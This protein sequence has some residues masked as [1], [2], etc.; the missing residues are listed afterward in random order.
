M[1]WTLGA[2][3]RGP[4]ALIVAGATIA[5]VSGLA[6]GLM[7]AI[8]AAWLQVAMAAAALPALYPLARVAA[9]TGP[10]GRLRRL[11]EGSWVDD[12]LGP[13]APPRIAV[14]GGAWMLMRL[15][16]RAAD[17]DARWVCAGRDAAG[18]VD[19]WAAVRRLVAAD[20]SRS[21]GESP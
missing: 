1:D 18:S 8:E 21:S 2:W 3:P 4:R 20:S 11:G 6:W 5:A 19:A 16:P 12:R 14:D 15:E 9:V 13:I 10:Q 17:L 7:A